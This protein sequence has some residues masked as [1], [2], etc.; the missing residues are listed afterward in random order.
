MTIVVCTFLIYSTVST[1]VFQTFACDYFADTKQSW[2]RAYYSI[3]CE[4]DKHTTYKAYAA[5]MI[6]VYPIG[7][8]LL[9]SVL[10]WR[11]R[12][13]LNPDSSNVVTR[14]IS[15]VWSAHITMLSR[16]RLLAGSS[17]YFKT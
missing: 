1:V 17:D 11:H 13:S 2:L 3:S 12:H 15:A 8:P 14:C 9:Y 6:A 7:I 10:L 16:G 5:V 4:A